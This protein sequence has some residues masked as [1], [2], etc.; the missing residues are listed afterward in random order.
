[1]DRLLQV[2]LGTLIWLNGA[3]L[4]IPDAGTIYRQTGNIKWNNGKRKAQRR[5]FLYRISLVT[6]YC[7][8]MHCFY[9]NQIYHSLI[10]QSSWQ[11]YFSLPGCIASGCFLNPFI[12]LKKYKPMMTALFILSVLVFIYLCYV[13][14][15]PEK[16]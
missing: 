1:M 13:L 15:K 16:F 6:G 3:L 5:C 11:H 14:I 4:A 12:F 10:N 8:Y 9:K 2:R 7:N